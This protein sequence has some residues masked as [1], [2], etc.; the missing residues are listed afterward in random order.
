MLVSYDGTAYSGWQLQPRAPTVQ[1][2]IERALTTVLRED[3]VPLSVSAAGRTDAGVHA[4]GQVVQFRTSRP[5]AIDGARLPG[6]LNSLLPHDIR[7]AWVRATAPDFNV[8]CSAT[9]KI[10]HYSIDT[11]RVHDPLVYRY[12][13]HC[14]RPLD[15]AAM[16]A[17]AAALV[18]TRD[19]TQF[20][21]NAPERQRRN[22]VKELRRLDVMEEGGGLRL[23]VEGSGFLYKQVRHMVG[24]LLAVGEG[25]LGLD[26]I[27]ERLEVGRSQPPGAGGAWRG[28]NVAPAKGLCLVRVFYPPEVDDPSALLHPALPHD[29]H[30]RLAAGA[31][32]ASGDED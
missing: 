30:G 3:R 28:Y 31:Q 10:Y 23:E 15:A 11:A 22:P 26:F 5:E 8:T 12:R 20:S 14:P 1:M 32:G 16:R 29:E 6:R 27:H 24:V 17:G 21:N 2:H 7:V 19:F 13:M 4:A 9:G 18:G 25:K